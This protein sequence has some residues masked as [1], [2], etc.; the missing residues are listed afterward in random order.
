[1][2]IKTKKEIDLMR[3]A[4]RI[5]ADLLR[6][7]EKYIK[8]GVSAFELNMIAEDFILSQ[9]GKP[10]FKGYGFSK[11]NRFPASICVSIDNEVVHGIPLPDKI[12]RE[13]QIVSIDVGVIKNGYY[14]D[15]ARTFAVGNISHEKRRLM[16]VAEKALYIG[17]EQ[18]IEGNRLN[19]IG[20]AIQ[21]FVESNGYSVVRDLV[22]HGIGRKLHEDPPVPNYGKKGTGKRLKEGVTLAIEPMVNTG[23]WQVFF[24]EDGW[25]VYTL[26]GLP[27][28]HF[29][30]TIVVKK[31]KPEI[32]TV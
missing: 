9:G 28:A 12:L 23:T 17:I 19:D 30:H 29:E 10:A 25:T 2:S 6:L 16:E 27:S 13:G 1:V 8:P 21:S 11:W 22:G 5:V 24:G 3:E 4:S 31:G 14:G 26:D 18:A 15:A 20:Y 7:L 32:L